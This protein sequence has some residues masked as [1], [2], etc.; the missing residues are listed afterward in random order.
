MEAMES[1]IMEYRV[2]QYIAYLSEEVHADHLVKTL[3]IK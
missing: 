2:Q 3:Q 1:A